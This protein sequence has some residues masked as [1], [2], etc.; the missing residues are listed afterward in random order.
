[1]RKKKP[2]RNN[3]LHKKIDK[4]F[5]NLKIILDISSYI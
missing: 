1:M 2:I 3:E 4:I 5:I